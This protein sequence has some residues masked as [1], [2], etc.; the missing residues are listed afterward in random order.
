M[1]N[2]GSFV[3]VLSRGLLDKP[4]SGGGL[5]KC[6]L[7]IGADLTELDDMVVFQVVI[8]TR[9]VVLFKPGIA[10]HFVCLLRK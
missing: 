8:L 9:M 5:D 4:V 1:S 10:D 3:V 7:N 6:N 2:R